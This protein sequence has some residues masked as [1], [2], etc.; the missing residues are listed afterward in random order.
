MT[1]RGDH[2]L[3]QALERAL[4]GEEARDA[5]S[6]PLRP[7]EEWELVA[8]AVELALLGDVRA[9]P[10]AHLAASLTRLLD[11]APKPPR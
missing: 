8:A 2:G 7:P 11:S 9:G 4:H 5:A 10:P 3:P 6:D 1:R